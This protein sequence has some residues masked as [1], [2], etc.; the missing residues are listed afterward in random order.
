MTV[1]QDA[2]RRVFWPERPAYSNGMLLDDRDFIAEQGYHRDRLARALAY[3]HG[4][5]T[6]AGLDVTIEAGSRWVE[7]FEDRHRQGRRIYR[8]VAKGF[9]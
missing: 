4:S 5:G 2:P 8:C 3:L 1:R 7:I 9:L 6:V